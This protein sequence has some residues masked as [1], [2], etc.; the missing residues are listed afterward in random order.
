MHPCA[1]STNA[2]LPLSGESWIE[3]ELALAARMGEAG[4][5][6]ATGAGIDHEIAASLFHFAV[7]R[8]LPKSQPI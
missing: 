3:G 5:V 1:A 8:F 2:R 4:G 7:A 6:E